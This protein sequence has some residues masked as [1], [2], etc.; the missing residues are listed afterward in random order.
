[1]KSVAQFRYL[2]AIV[3]MA[4]LAACAH[5]PYK[6]ADTTLDKAHVTLRSLETVQIEV[7]SLVNDPSI[8]ASVRTSLRQASQAATTSATEMGNAVIEVERIRTELAVGTTTED[9][10]KIANDNLLSWVDTVKKRIASIQ[11]AVKGAK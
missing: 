3:M 2:T 6:Y 9:K 10:L 11:S 8:P 1:M 7:L 5:N 4:A